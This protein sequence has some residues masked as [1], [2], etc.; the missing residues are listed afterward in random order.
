MKKLSDYAKVIRS[1]NAGPFSLTLDILFPQEKMY[2]KMKELDIFTKE[3]IAELYQIDEQ[4]IKD[5][6]WFD[7]AYGIKIVM[8]RSCFSGGPGDRDVYGAQQH[9]PLLQIKLPELD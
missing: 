9:A 4:S 8:K 6:I 5:I 1:K 3:R 7:P 2:L